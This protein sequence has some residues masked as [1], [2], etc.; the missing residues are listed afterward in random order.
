METITETRPVGRPRSDAT[1][2]AI[3]RAAYELL[4][5]GGLNRFTI[6]GVAARSGVARTTIYRWWPTKGALAMEG[7]L[8]AMSSDIDAPPTASAAHDIRVQIR[9]YAALLRGT[10]GTIIRGIIATAQGDPETTESFKTGFV[11]PRRAM[12]RITFARGIAAGEFRADLDIEM[13]LAGLYGALLVR[14]VLREDLD[15]AWVDRLLDTVLRN[16]AP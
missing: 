12:G 6:E 2:A 4:G 5:E 11:N 1:R 8:E 15:E 9:R 13:I 14:L 16:C 3:L 10:T 7:L